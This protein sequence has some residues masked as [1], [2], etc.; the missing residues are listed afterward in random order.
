[1]RDEGFST[2]EARAFDSRCGLVW[3][4]DASKVGERRVVHAESR[5]DATVELMIM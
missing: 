2:G 3:V 1:M 5:Y 4:I